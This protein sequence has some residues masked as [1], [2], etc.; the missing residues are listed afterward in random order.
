MIIKRTLCNDYKLYI[1]KKTFMIIVNNIK[2]RNEREESRRELNI[3][4][5]L[6]YYIM[7]CHV[8]KTAVLNR[9]VT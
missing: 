9:T 1:L 2:T 8:L 4:F 5:Y 7:L 6:W 3:S